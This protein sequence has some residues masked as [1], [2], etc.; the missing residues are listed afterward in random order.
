M[1][2]MKN[3]PIDYNL[4]FQTLEDK[5]QK[6]IEELNKIDVGHRDYQMII[7]NIVT[8]ANLVKNFAE[9]VPAAMGGTATGVKAGDEYKSINGNNEKDKIVIFI[10]DTCSFC[11]AM[12][13]VYIPALEKSHYKYEVINISN[14]KNAEFSKKLGITGVPAYLIVK[15]NIVKHRFEGFD[16]S[17][18]EKKNREDL[19]DLLKEHLGF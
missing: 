15:D 13:P 17:L 5:V 1:R 9:V 14:D 11:T 8:T 16:S 12:K 3:M 18:T 6:G 2:R 4:F 10:S 19:M 7:S